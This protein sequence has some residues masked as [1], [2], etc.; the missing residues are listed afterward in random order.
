MI[1]QFNSTGMIPIHQV[2][3]MMSFKSINTT[4]KWLE[5][6]GVKIHRVSNKKYVFEIDILSEIDKL[7]V[8]E[9][10]K[11]YP[12][13]WIEMYRTIATNPKVCEL[14]LLQIG[15]EPIQNSK[16]TMVK[17][18]NKKEEELLKQLLS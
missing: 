14:V 15:D 8:K 9:L 7:Q 10:K 12:E 18:K 2:S 11:R 13:K 16:Y 5:I 3:E 1:N 4:M 6:N 17:V